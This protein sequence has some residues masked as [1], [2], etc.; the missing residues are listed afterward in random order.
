MLSELHVAEII[1]Y[2]IEIMDHL[3]Y[4]NGFKTVAVQNCCLGNTLK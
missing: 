3:M 4:Y 1:L 2:Y